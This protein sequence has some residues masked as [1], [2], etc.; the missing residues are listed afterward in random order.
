MALSLKSLLARGPEI[1]RAERVLIREVPLEE[2]GLTLLYVL[3]AALWCIFSDDVLNWATGGPA[4]SPALR[5]MRG[6]NFVFT[7]A[8][9]LYL[10]LRRTIRTRRVAEEALRLSQER[11]EAAALA[12]T[13]A[14]WDLNLDTR[15]LWWSDGIQKLFGYPADEISSNFE[16]WRQ[17]VH[18]DDRD[19]VLESIRQVVD[20]GGRTWS[21]E[22]RFRRKDGTYAIIVDRGY[23]I[24]DAAGKPARLVGGLSDISE[25]RLAERA[26]ERSRQQLR[27]L[28][29]RLQE[30]REE[31]RANVAREIHDDLG[32]VLTALK[33]NLDWLERKIEEEKNGAPLN[34]F[35]DR[36]V[37]SQ[38]LIEGA[39]DSVQRIA[40]DLRP[41]LL[42]NLGLSEAL[43][44][45]SRRFRE[46]TS[47]PCEL[48]LPSQ[49]LKVSSEAAIAIFR[50][51]QEAL[52]NVVRHAQATQVQ[53]SLEN[54][55]R[56]VILQVEDNGKGIRP[57]ALNDPNS[58]G[59]LGM[60]ERALALGGQV[61]V[62]PVT[63]QGTRVTLQIPSQRSTAG[64]RRES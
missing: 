61:A 5:T 48:Q 18:D 4:E 49:P 27:A 15:V 53:V 33:L 64:T 35:L 55:D 43:R 57:E 13:D 32:Q 63:P 58:L 52:T 17:R 31:E 36:V 10:V 26:L 2:I 56:Q 54:N 41:A 59:L 30:G 45:E 42:D 8:L 46:R 21:G 24:P 9:V 6:F 47:L 14:I 22:Y 51:F 1:I 62:A 20:S 7:T 39:I 23:I 44:E 50:V 34:P 38:E 60:V 16:W 40:T 19:R 37:E 11:F 28:T 25:R 12:T 29:T 3:F